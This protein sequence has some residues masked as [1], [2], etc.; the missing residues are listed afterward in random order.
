MILI[1][2]ESALSVTCELTHPPHITSLIAPKTEVMRV[3]DFE[4]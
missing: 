4:G 3:S 2:C 1:L